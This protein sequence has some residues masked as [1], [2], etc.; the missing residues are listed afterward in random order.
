MRNLGLWRP[1]GFPPFPFLSELYVDDGLLFEIHNELRQRTNAKLR[2]STTMKL[3]GR[4]SVNLSKLEEEEEGEWKAAHTMF[5][6]HNDAQMRTIAHPVAKIAGHRVLFDK[7]NESRGSRALEVVT[8]QK[9][10]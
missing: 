7:L 5:G 3:L 9:V 10:R 2:A 6:F 1:G 4:Q 8:S